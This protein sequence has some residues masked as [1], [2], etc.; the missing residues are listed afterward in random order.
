[1]VFW[2]WG[3]GLESAYDNANI[4][5]LTRL[6][7]K[8][9]TPPKLLLPS[10][11]NPDLAPV[12]EIHDPEEDVNENERDVQLFLHQSSGEHL[13]LERIPV[14]AVFHRNDAAG[15]GVP[16]AFVSFLQRYPALPQAVVSPPLIRKV[17]S[18]Y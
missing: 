2:T 5:K 1:M 16:H 7:G 8:G 12:P 13:K 6:I 11:P 3:R 10:S 4:Q 15:R 14:L 17:V 9:P 18:L